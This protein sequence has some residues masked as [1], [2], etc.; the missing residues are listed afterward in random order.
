MRAGCARSARPQGA[1]RVLAQDAELSV[2]NCAVAL[3][4]KDTP[5]KEYTEAEL[6]PLIEQVLDQQ[7]AGPAPMDTTG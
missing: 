4:G 7:A 6:G 1:E 2:K 3:V 5:F